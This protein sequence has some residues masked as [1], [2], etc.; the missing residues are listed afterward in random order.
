MGSSNNNKQTQLKGNF[1]NK[2]QNIPNKYG[3]IPRPSDYNQNSNSILDSKEYNEYQRAVPNRITI[4]RENLIQDSVQ[5]KQKIN[6]ENLENKSLKKN[7]ANLESKCEELGNQIEN[8]KINMGIHTRQFGK[9]DIQS[10]N[11]A[12]Q[13]EIIRLS[14]ILEQIKSAQQ[15]L[16]ISEQDY[17]Y[18]LEKFKIQNKNVKEI[19]ENNRKLLGAIRNMQDGNNILQEQLEYLNQNYE[20]E[21]EHLEE[22]LKLLDQQILDAKG[23]IQFLQDNIQE[24]EQILNKDLNN[25]DQTEQ[26]KHKQQ[27]LEQQ[28]VEQYQKYINIEGILKDTKVKTERQLRQVKDKNQSLRIQIEQAKLQQEDLI[29]KNDPTQYEHVDKNLSAAQKSQI[30]EKIKLS[31]QNSLTNSL[32]SLQNNQDQNQKNLADSQAIHSQ[33]TVK[34]VTQIYQDDVKDIGRQLNLRL[35]AQDLTMQDIYN[36][37]VNDEEQVSSIALL[38]EIL[39]NEPFSLE[40]KD[41]ELIARYCV[42]ENNDVQS[43]RFKLNYNEQQNNRV[44]QSIF[45]KLLGTYHEFDEETQNKLY[46]EIQEMVKPRIQGFKTTLQEYVKEGIK[47]IDENTFCDICRSMDMDLNQQQKDYILVKIILESESSKNLNME[48]FLSFFSEEQINLHLKNKISS[49]QLGQ[50][51]YID[52]HQSYSSDQKSQEKNSIYDSFNDFKQQQELNKETEAQK[53]Q[54][55]QQTLNKKQNTT[56]FQDDSKQDNSQNNQLR[57]NG[58]FDDDIKKQK[59]SL[60]QKQKSQIKE[61]KKLNSSQQNSND[62]NSRVSLQDQHS[63]NNKN[64]DQ[65]QQSEK[66]ENQ[67]QLDNYN[68]QQSSENEVN[69]NNYNDETEEQQQQKKLNQIQNID[70]NNSQMTNSINNNNSKYVLVSNDLQNQLQQNEKE[71]ENENE[72]ENINNN[73]YQI[74]DQDR[75]EQNKLQQQNIVNGNKQEKQQENKNSSQYNEDEDNQ[76][77]EDEEMEEDLQQDNYEE[78]NSV[79]ED[80]N[81]QSQDQNNMNNQLQEESQNQYKESQILKQNEADVSQYLRDHQKNNSMNSSFSLKGEKSNIKKQDEEGQDYE[82]DFQDSKNQSQEQ[83]LDSD[84]VSNGSVEI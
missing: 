12:F 37:L 82:D 38:K 75:D 25:V 77:Y 23:N 60:L 74:I 21:N 8:L 76:Y 64:I 36:F 15:P 9:N 42:E 80:K 84:L 32:E 18:L 19:K 48:Y 17:A 52:D 70:Q 46:Y 55:Q 30:I 7:L 33:N 73:D 22:E 54:N 78:K 69:Q 2:K 62:N 13:D 43:Y 11:K 67:Q 56:N 39:N 68:I 14:H 31:R 41:A 4:D 3:A 44:I 83:K 71:N 20:T 1:V 40:E 51:V 57:Q 5:L 61:Q 6:E 29:K 45:R 49:N 16:N 10:E 27:N 72:N 66:L 26:L 58:D 79:L 34:F 28:L 81:G 24:K 53:N 35:R 65:S 50:Q 59:K 47:Q 63:L